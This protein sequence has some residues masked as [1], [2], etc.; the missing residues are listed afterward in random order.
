MLVFFALTT[1]TFLLDI[2]DPNQNTVPPSSNPLNTSSKISSSTSMQLQTESIN[3]HNILPD[4]NHPILKCFLVSNYWVFFGSHLNFIS[5]CITIMKYLQT[6]PYPELNN[7]YNAEN[8][9]YLLMKRS[10]RYII[11]VIK[12]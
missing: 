7:Y 8:S 5:K 9:S 10:G 11:W 12:T 1:Q 6:S 4:F 3:S 2:T